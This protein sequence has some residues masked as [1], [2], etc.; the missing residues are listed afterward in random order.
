M[1]K[2]RETTLQPERRVKLVQAAL[3]TAGKN[4]TKPLSPSFLK[5]ILKFLPTPLKLVGKRVLRLIPLLNAPLGRLE[6]AI[7]VRPL[8]YLWG[9]ER[10]KEIAR[11]YVEQFLQQFSSDIRGHCLEFRDNLYTTRFGENKV[12]RVDILDKSPSNRDATIVADLTRPNDIRNDSFDCIICTHVLHLIFERD[13][14]ISDL[15]RILKPGGVLLVAVPH[16]SMY[17]PNWHEFWRF[18]PEGL[19][20]V[21][22]KMFRSENVLVRAY[23]NSL[24]AAGE[25]RGLVVNEFTEDELNFHDERFAVEICA[26]A[27]KL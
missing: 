3:P 17:D 7:G 26:R 8:S 15:Y 1:T 20:G 9:S 4:H 23:G 12:T 16:V 6:L 5:S 19:C 2:A 22:A 10:G 25:I 14:A 11:Y 24:T 27:V 18:T 13:D 21:L